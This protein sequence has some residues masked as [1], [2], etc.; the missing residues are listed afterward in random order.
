MMKILFFQHFS[1]HVAYS[2]PLLLMSLHSFHGVHLDRHSLLNLEFIPSTFAAL[3]VSVKLS[4]ATNYNIL[5][6]S[7]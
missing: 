7:L 5:P 2:S 3:V 6:P 4:L 1:H